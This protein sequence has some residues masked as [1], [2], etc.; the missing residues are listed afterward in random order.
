M[1][2][3][4]IDVAPIVGNTADS[5]DEALKLFLSV[6]SYCPNCSNI[7]LDFANIEF[8]SRSFADQFLQEQRKFEK[9]GFTILP[10]NT[11]VQASQMFQAVSKTQSGR[12]IKEKE[13][14][15]RSLT[16]DE[17]YNFLINI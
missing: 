6:T 14:E 9:M 8:V 10:V 17:L 16:R 1:L 12:T 13:V 11:C 5:R 4:T 2:H 7:E 15:V 3:S